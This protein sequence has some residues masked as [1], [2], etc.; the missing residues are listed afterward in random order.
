VIEFLNERLSKDHTLFEYGSGN[1]T[2][3]F[4][5]RVDT[6][7]SVEHNPNWAE[8]IDPEL[9]ENAYLY[10][11]QDRDRYA[12][13]IELGVRKVP[14]NSFDVVVVDGNWRTACVEQAL[15]VVGDDGVV[16]LDDSSR[17]SYQDAKDRLK[18]EGYDQLTFRGMKPL[19]RDN[20]STSIFY[21]DENCLKI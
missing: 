5:K 8:R 2:K 13:S 21:H 16:V 17:S 11:K 15:S 18:N 10:T 12:Q 1:S 19:E 14:Q 4:S 20:S 3:W 6:V 9:P 7:V